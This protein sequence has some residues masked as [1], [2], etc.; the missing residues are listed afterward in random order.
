MMPINLNEAFCGC[1]RWVA[2]VNIEK[3]SEGTVRKWQICLLWDQDIG[4]PH[5]VWDTSHGDLFVL[6]IYN[7]V[8]IDI[9]YKISIKKICELINMRDYSL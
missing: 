9:V 3:V 4:G 6:G 5:R 8:L 1:L 7:C 2:Q